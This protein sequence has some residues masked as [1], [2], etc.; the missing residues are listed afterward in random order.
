M[1]STAKINYKIRTKFIN[2]EQVSI[3]AESKQVK[4]RNVVNVLRAR[5]IGYGT[6]FSDH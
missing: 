2:Y 3:K 5:I 6:H 4:R 1:P